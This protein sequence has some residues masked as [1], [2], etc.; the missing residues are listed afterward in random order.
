MREIAAPGVADAYG[1]RGEEQ[2]CIHAGRIER[3]GQPN[4]VRF[5]AI[6]PQ[7]IG[8]EVEERR[9]AEKRQRLD[10]AAAGI[11]QHAALVGDDDLRLAAPRQVTFDLVGEV[12]D[13]DHNRV[14]APGR[15]PVKH[16]IKERLPTDL[17]Q[18]LR[19]GVR[20]GT[21]TRAESGRQ[22]HGAF[23]HRGRGRAC[24]GQR[25]D[26]ATFYR[27]QHGNVTPEQLPGT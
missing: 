15:Q 23:R 20:Q 24:H 14:D 2:Q 9:S 4:K 6:D 25:I 12:V 19:L 17:D 11:E 5:D 7:R 26:P 22:H 8:V 16:M 27:K 13:V 10:H 1:G 21:H 3:F 18:R